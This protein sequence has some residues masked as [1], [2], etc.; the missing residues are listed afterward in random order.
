MKSADNTFDKHRHPDHG[1]LPNCGQRT[2]FDQS[3]GP[4]HRGLETN[5]ILP[6]E[7]VSPQLRPQS[8]VS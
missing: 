5:E 7:S 4:A 3:L 1:R 2:N 8:L 6:P